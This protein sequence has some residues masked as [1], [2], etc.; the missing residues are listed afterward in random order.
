MEDISTWFTWVNAIGYAGGLVTLW[1]FQ[2]R[3]MIPLRV[4]AIAGNIG[5]LLFGILAPSYPTLVLH[6]VLFPLN[7][8]RLTQSI[9]LIRDIQ[10]A[11]DGDGDLNAL[12]PFMTEERHKV[13]AHL[14]DKGDLPDSMI[15]ITEGEVLLE[16]LSVHCGPGDVLGEIAAF[17]PDNARTCTAVCVGEVRLYRLANETMLQLFYQNPRFGMYLVR[18]I[19][20]R[21]HRNWT[22]A[23]ER[24]KSL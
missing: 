7:A 1:G 13:G 11:A 9:R 3:T 23:E 18:L 14:F 4:G 5:F 20:H 22:D 6:A 12:I 8:W 15:V 24:A 2:Q 17:T 10:H 21:L 16:E 19:V